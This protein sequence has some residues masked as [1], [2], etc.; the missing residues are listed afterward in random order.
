MSECQASLKAYVTALGGNALLGFKI[1]ICNVTDLGY[2]N[3]VY[4]LMGISGDAVLTKH[5]HE[6]VSEDP[7]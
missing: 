6:N 1:D 2:K 7:L 4:C 3:Q 5:Q